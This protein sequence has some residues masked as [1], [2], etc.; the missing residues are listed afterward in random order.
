MDP[1]QKGNHHAADHDEVE[2]GDHEV[3]S[4]QSNVG[5]HGGKKQTGQSADGKQSD[6]GERVEHGALEDDRTFIHGRGPVEYFDGGRNCHEEGQEGENDAGVNALASDEHVMS[7]NQ[8]AENGDAHAGSGD[9]FVTEGA[10]AGEAGN[11]FANDAH[12]G[13]NH[14]VHGG[15]RIEPENVLKE[16]WISADV[17]IE[18]ADV[19]HSFDRD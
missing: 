19:H 10:F 9:E 13:K 16:D 15:V 17:W 11:H 8:E 4:V 5:C 7:P 3:C 6:E 14:D 18:N 1:R 2:V 12:A